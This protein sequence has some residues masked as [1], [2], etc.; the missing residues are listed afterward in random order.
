VI[1]PYTRIRELI[2]VH[3][4]ETDD[5]KEI[6]DLVIE[7]VMQDEEVLRALLQRNIRM[8]TN[9]YMG[10]VAREESERREVVGH[11]LEEM[12]SDKAIRLS[13][14]NRNIMVDMADMT[15]PQLEVLAAELD[16][17][18]DQAAEYAGF[19]RAIAKDLANGERVKDRY[20]ID[21]LHRAKSRITVLTDRR[22]FVGN[23]LIHSSNGKALK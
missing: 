14:S 15:R 19:V 21:D 18:S 7:D 2:R 9:R 20:T 8:E 5:R 17:E 6:A 12:T 3:M 11:R 10:Q 4:E 1:A 13:N 23:N 22:V 16:R